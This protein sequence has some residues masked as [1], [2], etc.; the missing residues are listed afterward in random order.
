MHINFPSALSFPRKQSVLKVLFL[1]WYSEATPC[2]WLLPARML[3]AF[4]S[5]WK[6]KII[7][8]GALDSSKFFLQLVMWAD[9]T[10]VWCPHRK[11]LPSANWERS[12]QFRQW[13]LVQ[14][15]TMPFVIRNSHPKIKWVSWT[16]DYLFFYFPTDCT[17]NLQA[18]SCGIDVSMIGLAGL[19][20]WILPSVSGLG[21]YW[22]SQADAH[23][24]EGHGVTGLGGILST[25]KVLLLGSRKSGRWE[26]RQCLTNCIVSLCTQGTAGVNRDG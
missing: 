2:Q 11:H 12:S 23:T 5:L 3:N 21:A 6:K 15:C 14:L 20:R 8:S 22:G 4:T 17:G 26:A 16:L 10:Y 19:V 1:D 25:R 9:L 18:R 7:K 24:W 13:S